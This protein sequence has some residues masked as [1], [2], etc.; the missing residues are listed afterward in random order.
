[1]ENPA[2][3]DVLVIGGG[4]GGSTTATFL[5]RRGKRVLLLEK[6][7]FPRFHI[8]ESLL[9][10]NRRIFREMGVLPVLEAAGF[11]PKHG[12]QFHLG[13]ASKSLYLQFRSGRFTRESLAFQVDRAKFDHLLLTHARSCGADV[14]EGWA[15]LATCSDSAGTRLEA[16]NPDGQVHTFTGAFLVDASGRGNF[17]GNQAGLRHIHTHHR[18]VAVFGHFSGV[19]IDPGEKGGDT[20]I[21]RLEHQWFWV[22]PLAPD[23]VSVGCVLEE[24]ELARAKQ[25]PEQLFFQLCASSAAMT[26]RMKN[27]QPVTRIQTTSDFSY[28]NRRLIGPRLIR[29]GDAAGFMDPIF[30]AGVFLAMHSGQ[31]AADIIDQSLAHGEDGARQLRRYEKRMFSAMRLYWHMVEQFYT[32]PFLEVFLEPRHRLDIPAAVTAILAGELKGGWALWWRLRL[33]FLIVRVQAWWPL[34]PRLCFK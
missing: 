33:F 19:A 14:R 34:L 16:R 25:S 5:A 9:P 20:V 22:I 31:L 28:Y 4:P 7:H 18:K 15:V 17:T 21:V 13:N 1:M 12:A 24:R 3:Y 30:S 2:H 27:A 32:T 29:I 8:G 23:R 6:E 11:T 26:E 10:Y